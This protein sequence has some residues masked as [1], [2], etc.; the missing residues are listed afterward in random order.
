MSGSSDRERGLGEGTG[1]GC[2]EGVAGE[3][4]LPRGLTGGGS[5]LELALVLDM[6][7]NNSKSSAVYMRSATNDSLSSASWPEYLSY[8]STKL[9]KSNP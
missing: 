7:T 9:L 6:A 5:T 1:G 8:S 3:A 4:G 2:S